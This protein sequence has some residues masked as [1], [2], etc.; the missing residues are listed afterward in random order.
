[1]PIY[2]YRCRSCKNC[3]ERLVPAGAADGQSC[4]TCGS[5]DVSRLLSLFAAPAGAGAAE[6]SGGGGSCCSGGGCSC[7]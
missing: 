5:A 6:A 1:M 3:F 4:P 2:E 7:H